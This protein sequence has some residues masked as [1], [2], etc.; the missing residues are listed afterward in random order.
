MATSRQLSAEQ[1]KAC[2]LK[3]ARELFLSQGFQGT[4]TRGIADSCLI[5]QPN[6]YH[7]FGNKQQLF[8]RVIEDLV[9]EV[10]SAQRALLA[11]DL[12]VEEKLLAMVKV[13]LD[14]HPA[15][16]FVMMADIKRYAS[17]N[18]PR[19]LYNMYQQAYTAP[20]E[21][22]FETLPLRNGVTPAEATTHLMYHLGALMSLANVYDK[23]QTEEQLAKT[24]DFLLYGL[25]HDNAGK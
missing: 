20:L 22:V 4:S 8:Q 9:S 3:V 11:T 23:D 12:P 15:N 19:A 1:T 7:H 25:A 10:E 6:L 5:T 13:L 2:I 14:K 17:D 18:N 16:F 24:L 21:E